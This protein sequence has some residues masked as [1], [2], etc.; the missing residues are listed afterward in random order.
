LKS[1]NIAIVF[2]LAIALAACGPAG[3]SVTESPTITATSSPVPSATQTPTETPVP[4]PTVPPF[5]LSATVWTQTPQVPL[6]LY[7]Q[8]A[9]NHA[10]QSTYMKVRF[11]DFGLQLEALNQ[12]GYT[13]VAFEDWVAGEMTLPAGRRPLI[14]TMD[15]LFFNNQVRLGEDGN[16][17]PETGL[18]IAWDYA[19]QHPEFGFKYLLFATLG[20]KY[21]GAGDEAGAWKTELG[22][23]IAWCLDHGATVYSH[24]YTHTDLQITDAAGIKWEL[25]MNDKFLREL[26]A[27]VGREDLIPGLG[28]MIAIPYGKYPDGKDRLGAIFD[29]TN[30]EGL[31]MQYAFTVDFVV[32]PD[33]LDPVYSPEFDRFY[34]PR[35][36]AN[37][38][39]I[40]FLIQNKDSFPAASECRLGPLDETLAGEAGYLETQIAAAVTAGACPVG[41]YVVSGFVFDAQPTSV[42]LILP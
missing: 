26:L 31:P 20:D 25:M 2:I 10:K 40:E 18:G 7:H 24:T 3:A 23:T 11:E 33:Y 8:F 1:S 9:A 35:I 27:L 32:R 17:R 37:P 29:Y 12:A 19:R 22:Q 14:I 21:Y 36:N 15:D 6:L 5:Y 38:D 39:A 30:P 28:N 41:T 13:L 16:P 42:A 34:V 4:T